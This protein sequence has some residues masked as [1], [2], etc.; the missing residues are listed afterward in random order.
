MCPRTDYEIETLSNA[1]NP[2]YAT[3]WKPVG[4]SATPGLPF[5]LKITTWDTAAGQRDTTV[6][7]DDFIPVAEK[8]V[9]YN[10]SI[11]LSIYF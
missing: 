2:A 1:A 3:N 11:W 10:S 4:T 8:K 7:L 6:L 5:K 9:F